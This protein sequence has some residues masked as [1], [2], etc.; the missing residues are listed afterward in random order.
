MHGP[1][2]TMRT[3]RAQVDQI[4]RPRLGKSILNRLSPKQLDDFYG[5]MKDEGRSPR[6]IRNYPT[7]IAGSY[8]V[9]V[10]ALTRA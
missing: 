6:T 10:G 3:H 1:P 5:Q 9:A 2:T 7:I 4:V 8:D